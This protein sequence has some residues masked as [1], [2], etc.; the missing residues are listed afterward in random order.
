MFE[1]KTVGKLVYD[2][3][4]ADMKRRTEGWCILEVDREIT[5]Y[6]RERLRSELHLHLQPPSWDAHVSVVRGERLATD[7]RHLWKKYANKRI[8]IAYSLPGEYY[9]GRS[10]LKDKQ[11]DGGRFFIVNIK[12]QELMDIRHELG[13]PTNWSLHLTFGRIYEYEARAPKR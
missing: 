6:Y 13:L 9:E 3:Y 4:R 8:E 2:P 12:S 1:H 11:V 10:H 7:K 5:R